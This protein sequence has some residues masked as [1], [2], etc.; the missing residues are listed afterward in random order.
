MII[1]MEINWL[2]EEEEDEAKIWWYFII[3]VR[4]SIESQCNFGGYGWLMKCL[5]VLMI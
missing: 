2:L 1:W 5:L 3:D 4:V